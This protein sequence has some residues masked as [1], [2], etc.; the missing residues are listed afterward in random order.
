MYGYLK[1]LVK[2]TRF[3]NHI[4]DTRNITDNPPRLKILHDKYSSWKGR[5]V[6][7]MFKFFYT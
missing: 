5:S 1:L 7:R 4:L 6:T 2:S 3:N